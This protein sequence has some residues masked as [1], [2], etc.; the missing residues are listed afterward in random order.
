MT[1]IPKSTCEKL[2]EMGCVSENTDIYWSAQHQNKLIKGSYDWCFEVKLPN[3]PAFTPWDF[4]GTSERARENARILWGDMKVVA[5]NGPHYK[6][7]DPHT[8]FE[9]NRHACID[10]PDAVEFIVRAVEERGCS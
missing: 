2:E 10:S 8:G 1:F 4:V 6:I 7:Y 9:H 3:I 5:N